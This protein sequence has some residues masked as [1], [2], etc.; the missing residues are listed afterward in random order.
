MAVRAASTACIL[1][2]ISPCRPRPAFGKAPSTVR[3]AQEEASI[4]GET[5]KEGS[6]IWDVS[7]TRIRSK[8]GWRRAVAL[9][10]VRFRH[11]FPLPF[12]PLP[13]ANHPAQVAFSPRI[14]LRATDAALRSSNPDGKENTDVVCDGYRVPTS[15][16]Q[17]G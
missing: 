7:A 9:L 4:A 1:G 15:P 11:D 3:G 10:R 5:C 2:V 14:M 17:A 13:T 16:H 12:R 6:F 8:Q